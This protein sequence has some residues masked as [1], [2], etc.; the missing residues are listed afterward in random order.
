MSYSKTEWVSNQ[1]PLSADNMNHIEQGIFD[2]D[3]NKADKIGSL[4]EYN[5]NLELVLDFISTTH[6][7]KK[8]II[9]NYNGT[10]YL[11]KFDS[12]GPTNYRFDFIALEGTPR[13][14]ASEGPTG[15]DL[16]NLQFSDILTAT[17]RRDYILNDSV[18]PYVVASPSDTIADFCTTNNSINKVF[19]VQFMGSSYI[20]ITTT[21]GNNNYLFEFKAIQ[22]N[23]KYSGSVVGTSKFQNIFSATYA[24]NYEVTTNKVDTL[25][26]SSTTSQYPNAKLVYDQLALKANDNSVVHLDGYETISGHKTFM[27]NMTIGSDY[28]IYEDDGSRFILAYHGTDYIL[29]NENANLFTNRN[30]LSYMNNSRDLGSS[31]YTW[32]DLYLGGL[33][34]RNSS[35]YGL[36]IPTTTSWSANK[37]I[38]TTDDISSYHDSTKENISNKVTSLSSSSTNTQYPSAKLVYDQLELK[39]NK[40]GPLPS[41]NFIAQ[42]N[43]VTSIT[44]Y[45]LKGLPFVFIYNGFP[46]LAV[47]S[48]NAGNYD[49]EIENLTNSDRWVGTNVYLDGKTPSDILTNTYKQ[50]YELESNKVT[51]I[52][53]SSTNTQYPSA[54]LV[55]D[56]LALKEDKSNKVTS[57]TYSSTDT[58]YPSAKCVYD[59]VTKINEEFRKKCNT[60]ALDT[61]TLAPTSSTFAN[62][63]YY[64]EYG[65]R[66]ETYQDYVNYLDRVNLGTFFNEEF[67]YQASSEKFTNNPPDA[68]ILVTLQK[69]NPKKLQIIG[70]EGI[71]HSSAL[72]NGDII[73]VINDNIP[74][75]WYFDY[76]FYAYKPVLQDLSSYV[77]GPASSTENALAVYSDTSGKLLKNS[78][79]TFGTT[80]SL[81]LNALQTNNRLISLKSNSV[82]FRV[83]KVTSDATRASIYGT[84]L[85]PTPSALD[86]GN[87]SNIF[88]DLYMN[89]FIKDGRSSYGLTIP[90]TSTWSSNKNIALVEDLGNTCV[91]LSGDQEISGSKQFIGNFSIV[92]S[93][94][95]FGLSDA[96]YVEGWTEISNS[97]IVFDDY[98]SMRRGS[99]EYGVKL[100]DMSSWTTDRTLATTDD[101]IGI[102][103][104][105]AQTLGVNSSSFAES[106]DLL[107][108]RFYYFQ[109]KSSSSGHGA[110]SFGLIYLD[111]SVFIGGPVVI[112]SAGREYNYNTTSYNIEL[113]LSYNTTS[114]KWSAKINNLSNSTSLS[115]TLSFFLAG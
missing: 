29:R 21:T 57:I 30:L 31:S 42:T 81:S 38:A 17:Y 53:A 100:P 9:I 36:A 101:I 3:A 91:T 64:D 73:H 87:S 105:P 75:R 35:N 71:L 49:F 55:Y 52:S 37:T 79:F 33:I 107:S 97:T 114:H 93:N 65:N 15:I 66:L 40:Q 108:G 94:A 56:K 61:T 45:Q 90:N 89:G 68:Y 59:E 16:S 70:L 25:S 84:T 18:L 47:F 60:Y 19:I 96:I 34:N 5:P 92:N 2:N 50:N 83:G 82:D 80:T 12:A 67:E 23:V 113:Q 28:S 109:Y 27:G 98:T 115:G 24:N 14:Y 110:T 7:D 77:E 58:Q 46:Y 111:T 13:R 1:T 10:R 11:G 8:P 62:A 104:G 63:E 44:Y 26:A 88:A 112:T 54:K 51:S 32:H 4:P 22:G 99:G 86:I 103:F 43:I 95:S 41:F 6:C 76:W 74:D 20:G 72:N 39:A 48:P 69:S 102:G 85:N 78:A 106:S